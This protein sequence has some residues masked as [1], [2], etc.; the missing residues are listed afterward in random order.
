M[1]ILT[2]SLGVESLCH[3]REVPGS[4]LVRRQAIMIAF[5]QDFSYFFREDR[6][7]LN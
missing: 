1:K 5:F 6:P 7:T 3:I 4:N 2:Q